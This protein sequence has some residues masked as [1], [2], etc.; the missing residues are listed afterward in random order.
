[1]SWI[2]SGAARKLWAPHDDVV[3]GLRWTPDGLLAATGNRG[4]I[5]RVQ[6]N[7]EFADIAH[8]EASQAT[9][10]ATAPDGFYVGTSNGGKLFHLGAR[11][12]E[13][14]IESDVQDAGAVARWGRADV[15]ATGSGYQLSVRTGNVSNAERGWSAMEDRSPRRRRSLRR[16]RALRSGSSR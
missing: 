10:F 15:D 12:A 8:L 3:Y 2:H 13:G 7:G 1:M 6:E 11:S 9:G 14:S 5:Y 16:R 4:R